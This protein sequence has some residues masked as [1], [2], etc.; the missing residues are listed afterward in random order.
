MRIAFAGTPE[1]AAAALA[2]LL[3]AGFEVGLVL[4][5][6]DRPAG[7]GQRSQP[8]AVRRLAQARGIAVA[9]PLSLR[10]ERGGAATMEALA[11]L[12]SLAPDVLVVAAYG[13]LL[14]PAVLQM[15]RGL[16]TQM[17]AATAVNIH[18]SLLPRWRGAAPIVRAIEAGDAC[19]GISIMQMDAGLDTGP[20]L[21]SESIAIDADATAAS[22]GAQLAQLGA[23]ML[24]ETLHAAARGVLRARPQ[25]EQGV[26]YA[27][28]VEKREAW[29]DWSAP[30]PVIAARVRAFD[31]FPGACSLLERT[32]LKIW[33]AHA[34][35]DEARAAGIARAAPAAGWQPGTIVEAG[36]AGIVVACG[37]RGPA[38][39]SRLLC[40]TQLQRPGGRRMD[41]R[42]F[43]AGTPIV[44]GAAGSILR[45][46]QAP[47]D[48]S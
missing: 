13:L 7:R 26:C 20:I 46:A 11:R 9:T 29:I 2:A 39:A 48:E 36:P 3:D 15:P 37:P 5:Q 6:P 23:R 22:L 44:P 32:T 27:H 24:V 16:P 14:P 47:V 10:P 41:A 30:A 17:G 12:Q 18:A 35:R 8:S 1:F 45:R 34:M 38:D 21:S 4:S 33:R 40:V 43:L 31:P 25:P 28:K 42:D 19:T